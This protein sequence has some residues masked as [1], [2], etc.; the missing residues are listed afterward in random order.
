[1]S[2]RFPAL[3]RPASAKGVQQVSK[4]APLEPRPKPLAKAMVP[5]APPLQSKKD[6]VA[7]EERLFEQE[8]MKKNPLISLYKRVDQE[9]LEKVGLSHKSDINTE[10]GGLK[11]LYDYSMLQR[12]R[13]ERAF[14][15]VDTYKPAVATKEEAD[16]LKEKER[17]WWK[18]NAVTKQQKIVE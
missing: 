6:K 15:K 18:E 10:Q 2:K 8:E 17:D 4:M 1:M 12:F 3:P 7:A 9:Q 13:G 14:F 5:K 11:S 16:Q